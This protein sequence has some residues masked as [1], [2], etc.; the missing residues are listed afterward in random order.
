M[1]GH[2]TPVGWAQPKERFPST[3]ETPVP[4]MPIGEVGFAGTSSEY[5]TFRGQL[6]EIARLGPSVD[7]YG[8]S[9]TGLGTPRPAFACFVDISSY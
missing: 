6:L 2:C 1:Q 5:R 4:L 8:E 9:M 3:L 7:C